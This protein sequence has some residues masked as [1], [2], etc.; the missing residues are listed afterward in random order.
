MAS[1][2]TDA[3]VCATC[4]AAPVVNGNHPCVTVKMPVMCLNDIPN[5]MHK[6]GWTVS[7]KLMRKWFSVS[8]DHAM[9]TAQRTGQGVNYLALSADRI[10][11]QTVKMSWAL[12]YKPVKKALNDLYHEWATP[13]SMQLL[14]GRLSAVGWQSG[15]TARLG[16]GLTRAIELDM[17]C[18]VNYR[19]FGSITDDFDDFFGA[20]NIGTLKVALIGTASFDQARNCDIFKIDGMGFYIRDTYDFNVGGRIIDRVQERAVGLGVWSK[21]K[22]LNK[23][24]TLDYS[25]Y[26]SRVLMSPLVALSA[27]VTPD[28]SVAEAMKMLYSKYNGFVPVYNQDFRDWQN[29]NKTGGD[30]FVFSDVHW[31][32]PN[33][34]EVVIP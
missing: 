34:K 26:F 1:I 15:G 8:P 10:D 3:K 4:V 29:K 13:K 22:V 21:S 24:E 2:N 33:V 17:T 12:G 28:A 9:T 25:T 18:Q 32:V 30:F 11:D 27:L 23:E 16:Y 20:I 14:R 6:M 7:E 19:E 31:V 5:A